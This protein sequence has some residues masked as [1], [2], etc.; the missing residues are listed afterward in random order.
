MICRIDDMRSRQVV[1]INSG[2]VLGYVCDIEFD[3][4]SGALS[5]IVIYGRQKVFGLFGKEDDIKIPWSEI[6]VIGE[7]TVLVKTEPLSL[8]RSF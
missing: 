4:Q 2:T 8:Q 6:E 7:E 3:T 1:C 5:S